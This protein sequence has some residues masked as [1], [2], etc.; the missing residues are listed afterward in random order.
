MTPPTIAY[1]STLRIQM[2]KNKPSCLTLGPI[3]KREQK[4][5]ADGKRKLYGGEN[6]RPF[7]FNHGRSL[8]SLTSISLD[9]LS[10]TVFG[11]SKPTAFEWLN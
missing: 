3:E 7:L 6:Y 1:A 9:I 10:W 4:V 11:F 2:P 8:C 5:E